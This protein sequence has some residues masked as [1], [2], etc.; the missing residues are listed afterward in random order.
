MNRC[1]YPLTLLYDGSCPVC[2]LEM[3]H[4]MARNALNR[5]AFVDI[6][7]AG[8]DAAARTGGQAT[9]AQMQDLIHGLRPDG[10]LLVGAQVL[11]LAYEAVGLGA[12]VAPLAVPGLQPL[13]ERVYVAFA[14]NRYGISRLLGPAIRQLAAYRAVRRAS[15]CADGACER[16]VHP[17]TTDERSLS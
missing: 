8:F 14:R 7:A 1:D 16:P 5:L 11:R 15:A 2:L 10:S 12:W 17:Q 3:E 6:S 9:L 4:L 13:G